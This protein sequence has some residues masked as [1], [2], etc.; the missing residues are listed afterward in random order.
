MKIRRLLSFV[1]SIFFMFLLGGLAVW[2]ADSSDPWCTFQGKNY[3]RF[4][5]PKR[6]E[7]YTT[8]I[9]VEAQLEKSASAQ[10]SFSQLKF[11]NPK[12]LLDKSNLKR[13]KVSKVVAGQYHA[14][15]LYIDC[16]ANACS[17]LKGLK[18]Q[19]KYRLR[20][21]RNDTPFFRQGLKV[22]SYHLIDTTD[23]QQI[24]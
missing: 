13:F 15:D 16:S 1:A 14:S 3:C 6:P 18:P 22:P 11:S 5:N 8:R 20:L 17:V 12:G 10:P 4:H 2:N 19:A 23:L 21:S 7:A 24:P 9:I